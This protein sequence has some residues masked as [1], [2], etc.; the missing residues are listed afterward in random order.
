MS[1]SMSYSRVIEVINENGLSW[2]EIDR[3]ELRDDAYDEFKQRASFDPSNYSTTDKPAVRK[4]S[5][6]E[7]VIYVNKDGHEVTLTL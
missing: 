4:T 6:E 3:I 5:G 1:R 7:R 2:R